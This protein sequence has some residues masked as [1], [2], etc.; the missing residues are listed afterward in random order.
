MKERHKNPLDK[1]KTYPISERKNKVKKEDFALPPE[2]GKSFVD[3]YKGLPSILA[4]KDLRILIEDIISARQKGRSV[5]FMLGAHVIKCGLNPVIIELLKRK[6]ITCLA[7]NGAGCIHDFEI[8]LIGQTS[9][10]VAKGIEDGSFGMS[11]ET[12]RMINEA[13]I[14]GVERKAGIGI[15]VGRIISQRKL[16]WRNLSLLYHCWRLRIPA[17]VHVALGTDIIHQHPACSGAALGEGSIL[18]FQ[19]FIRQ[20]AG[21]DNG[22]VL[23]N[24]GSAVILPEVFLKAL[25]VTRNIEPQVKDFTTANFDMVRHYRPM[26]NILHRPILSGGRSYNFIGQHE[27]MIPLLAQ[28]IIEQLTH[29]NNKS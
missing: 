27:I 4:A 7:F 8:A 1:V 25:T 14:A 19:K 23:V 29:V 16:R 17:T 5:I 6:I 20:V 15:S 21:L 2:P 10:D 24:V 13:V 12:G 9:E 26:E 28:A 22:G 18:D 11:E 3:F